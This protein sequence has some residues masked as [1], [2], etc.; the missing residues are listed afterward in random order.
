MFFIVI[1]H[2]NP[3]NGLG[4][5]GNAINYLAVAFARFAVP[6]FFIVPGYLFTKSLDKNDGISYTVSYL[7]KLLSLYTISIVTSLPVEAVLTVGR[8]IN[9]KQDVMAM[10]GTRLFNVFSP[11]SSVYYGDSVSSSLWFLPALAYAIVIVHLAV[12]T[13]MVTY[14]LP[15]AFTFHFVG[16]FGQGY[17]VLF[18]MPFDTSDT[19]S[20]GMLHTLI[21]SFLSAETR[22]PR[23]ESRT[24]R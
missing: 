8:A 21:G 14:L 18:R 20:F 1:I 13:D 2:K 24:A 7:K 22:A 4:I 17:G 12:R 9:Y 19:P 10:L 16:Q 11:L 15:I 23:Q 3:F 5:V 6:F